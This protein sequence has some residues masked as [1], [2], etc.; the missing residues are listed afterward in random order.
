MRY[1]SGTDYDAVWDQQDQRDRK[2][3]FR[4][5][6]RRESLRNYRA[7]QAARRAVTA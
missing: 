3:I 5:K 6:A 7:L 4:T 1:V 2:R